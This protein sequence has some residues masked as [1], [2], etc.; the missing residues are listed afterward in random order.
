MTSAPQAGPGAASTANTPDAA[1][2]PDAPGDGAATSADGARGLAERAAAL[3]RE[4]A[5]ALVSAD[6]EARLAAQLRELAARLGGLAGPAP[7]DGTPPADTRARAAAH[8][9]QEPASRSGAVGPDEDDSP[10]RRGDITPISSPRN[11]LAPP[12]VIERE[13]DGSAVGRASLPLQYQGPP[14]RVHGGIVCLML[15]QVLGSAAHPKGAAPAYTRV[16]EVEYLAA[17]P[18]DAPLTVRGWIERTEGRKRFLAGT[19]AHG[20]TITARATGLWVAPREAG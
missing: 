5:T 20:D 9:G 10:V 14:E 4:L 18:L 6:D 12:L 15:D 19:V 1:D 11:P 3:G 13:A 2:A 17:T 7:A 16:L 8:H